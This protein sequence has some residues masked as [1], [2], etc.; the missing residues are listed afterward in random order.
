MSPLKTTHP[1]PAISNAIV[2]SVDPVTGISSLPPPTPSV[3]TNA[4]SVLVGVGSVMTA[5]LVGVGEVVIDTVGVNFMVGVAVGN[6]CVVSAVVTIDSVVVAPV[7][8]TDAV[9]KVVITFVVSV[10]PDPNVV[11]SNF[12]CT[13]VVVA[14]FP[15]NLTMAIVPVPCIGAVVLFAATVMDAVPAPTTP[16]AVIFG[17][18][19]P[20]VML[21]ASN[22]VESKVTTTLT[23]VTLLVPVFMS[24]L[25]EN[26]SSTGLVTVV[27]ENES[28]VAGAAL[29]RISCCCPIKYTIAGIVR[30]SRIPTTKKTIFFILYLV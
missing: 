22:F 10:S 24:T 17:A 21:A 13:G 4:L 15:L 25:T 26:C 5:V 12:N 1:M 8:V 30:R 23:A 6:T 16:E 14:A 11:V 28:V 2:F 27:G 7:M 29:L 9:P 19:A 3:A 20:L 18:N